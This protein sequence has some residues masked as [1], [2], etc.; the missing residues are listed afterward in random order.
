MTTSDNRSIDDSLASSVERSLPERPVHPAPESLIVRLATPEDI[1]AIHAITHEAF[2]NYARDLGLPGQV[3]ALVETHED[4]L[5]DLQ[6]KRVFVAV[7]DGAVVGSVRCEHMNN[8]GMGYI[9]R[10]GVKRGIRGGGAGNALIE[11]AAEDAKA[12]GLN[13]LVLHTSSKMFPLMRFYYGQGFYV[14]ATA[15]DR[16]YVRALLVRELTPDGANI[17]VAA[18]GN[19]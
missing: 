7:Q 19:R 14:Y 15:R 3:K 6:Q 9:G 2:T 10:F 18:L 5:R 12:A 17:D 13:A 11:A 4:V 8:V 16:G 1:P